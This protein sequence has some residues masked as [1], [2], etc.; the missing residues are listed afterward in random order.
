[1]TSMMGGALR[2]LRGLETLQRT[3]STFCPSLFKMGR[4][5]GAKVASTM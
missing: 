1:M 5:F 4:K 2:S 3:M